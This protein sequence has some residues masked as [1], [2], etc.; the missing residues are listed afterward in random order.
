MKNQIKSHVEVVE[1]NKVEQNLDQIRKDCFTEPE[2]SEL[3]NKHIQTLAGFY[4][5]KVALKKLL[6]QLYPDQMISEKQIIITHNLD[7][8]PYINEII[9]FMNDDIKKLQISI[10]HTSENAYGFAA[11]IETMK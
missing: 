1:I 6:D 8:A 2:L 9:S 5:V 11:I 4:A 10:S 7:G 3:S